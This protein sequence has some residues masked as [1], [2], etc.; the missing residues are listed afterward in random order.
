MLSVQI[1]ILSEADIMTKNVSN[2]VYCFYPIGVVDWDAQIRTYISHL[3]TYLAVS[4]EI[5]IWKIAKMLT[6]RY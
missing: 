4:W 2:I 1:S 6:T 3:S 5:R